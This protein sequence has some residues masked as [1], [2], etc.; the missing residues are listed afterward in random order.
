[1]AFGGH[2]HT[3]APNLQADMRRRRP[4][5]NTK[6]AWSASRA[7]RL[8]PARSVNRLGRSGRDRAIRLAGNVGVV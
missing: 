1:M 4:P 3:E 5:L 2:S 8:P 6:A 7:A